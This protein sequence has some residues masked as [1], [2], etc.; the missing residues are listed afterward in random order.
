MRWLAHSEMFGAM[1]TAELDTEIL[2]YWWPDNQPDPRS[3]RGSINILL[4]PA[5]WTEP[6]AVEMCVLAAAG[7]WSFVALHYKASKVYIFVPIFGEFHWNGLACTWASLTWTLGIV[8]ILLV[9]L[10]SLSWTVWKCTR[11]THSSS[12]PAFMVLPC[13]C[14]RVWESLAGANVLLLAEECRPG[15]LWWEWAT[16]LQV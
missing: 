1:E 2:R 9:Y 16:E 4:Q 13:T 8:N 15:R 12:S 7:V 5:N 3:W 14:P 11:V 6:G 10:E